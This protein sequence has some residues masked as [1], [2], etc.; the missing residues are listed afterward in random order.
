MKAQLTINGQTVV[1]STATE[2]MQQYFLMHQ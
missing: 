2:Q 1:S